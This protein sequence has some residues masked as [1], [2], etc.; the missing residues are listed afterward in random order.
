MSVPADRQ[1]YAGIFVDEVGQRLLA[2]SLAQLDA[3]IGTAWRACQTK[4]AS[5]ELYERCLDLVESWNERVYEEEARVLTDQPG[6]GEA[7]QEA[8]VRY[9]RD[10]FRGRARPHGK[11][12]LTRP[13]DVAYVQALIGAAVRHRGVRSGRMFDDA[14][15]LERKDAGMDIVRDAFVHLQR[16]FVLVEPLPAGPATAVGSLAQADVSPADS[17]SQVGSPYRGEGAEPPTERRLSPA[18]SSASSSA[19]PSGEVRSVTVAT[20]V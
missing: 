8:F 14:A 17:A 2:C 3:T 10:M 7:V 19:P 16:E 4:E 6:G 18:A 1:L 9:V 5:A 13:S 11:V 20:H 12:H 15:P